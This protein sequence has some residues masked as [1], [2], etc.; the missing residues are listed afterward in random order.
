[1]TV[2]EHAT[3][4]PTP[5]EPAAWLLIAAAAVTVVL[6]SSAFVAVRFVGALCLLGVWLSRRRA[7]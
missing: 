4:A 2:D 1:M 7:G 5:V 3:S 6:W